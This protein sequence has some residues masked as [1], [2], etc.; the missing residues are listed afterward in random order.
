MLAGAR[1]LRRVAGPGS[2][3]QVSGTPAPDL[4]IGAFSNRGPWV[5][6]PERMPWRADVDALRARGQAEVPELV[7]KRVVPPLVRFT[8]AAVLLGASLV[9]WR[10]REQ[11][12]GGAVSRAGLSRRLRRA[13]ER[14]G[15]AYIKLGQIVSSG[16]GFF[17]PELVDE[18]KRCRDQVPAEPFDVVR[19]VV[20]EEV[21]GPLERT[22][23]SFDERPIAAAS[24]AQVHAA[25][26][27]SGQ[28]V[29]V[30]VQRPQVA[31]LVRR[32]IQAMG[33]IAPLLVGRI[34]VAALAN[35]PALVELF[36]ETI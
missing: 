12:A 16:Q 14:L 31:R 25:E 29:V 33:W 6:D 9:G 36:A 28:R 27:H 35:P 2:P 13:F 22:F 32:D 34:P 11:R 24:I 3:K 10:L 23:A 5:V 8:E 4:A 7:R 18:F 26:L 30:K 1:G 15:P 21:G 17:P 20:E 19:R